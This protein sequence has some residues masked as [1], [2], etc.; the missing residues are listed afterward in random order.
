MQRFLQ[1]QRTN[2]KYLRLLFNDHFVVFLLIAFGVGVLGYRQL[3]ISPSLNVIWQSNWWRLIEVIWLL[4]GLQVGTIVSYLKPAD[5]LYLMGSDQIIIRNY[6]NHSMILSVIYASVWQIV[7]VAML[8]PI[9]L[10]TYMTFTSLIVLM[11]FMVC[12]KWLLLL[13]TRDSFFIN[14]RFVGFE[15]HSVIQ[16]LLLR[17]LL[18]ALAIVLLINVS[19]NHI[20]LFGIVWLILVVVLV[21]IT[22]ISESKSYSLAINWPIVVAQAM[23]HEQ[24]VLRFY[25][26][27]AEVPNQLRTSKR[28]RYL[29]KVINLL[30]K[31]QTSI[32]RLYVTRFVRDAE[33][34]PLVIR[35]VSVGV[36]ILYALNHAPIWLITGIASLMLYLVVFQIV[37]LYTT[38]EQN[39]WTRLL[40]IDSKSKQEAFSHVMN[41]IMAIIIVLLMCINAIHGWAVIITVGITM[42]I[43]GLFLN[44]FYIPSKIKRK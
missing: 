41:Q 27:F 20:W 29:D 42:S 11:L 13:T 2:M 22:H 18:P 4:L 44:H 25:A 19:L 16:K 9:L 15:S 24:R 17:F 28:R 35:L 10:Q 26:T 43:V 23:A 38:T 7:F 37:P 33:L 39:I 8:I 40:P 21:K 36:I 32:Y 6:F 34:L 1:A 30:A 31:E 5:R 3:I 14:T 12:Y